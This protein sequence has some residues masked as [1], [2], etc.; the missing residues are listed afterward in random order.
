MS[1]GSAQRWLLA[2]LAVLLGAL[3]YLN[4]LH[5]PFV[6]DDHSTVVGNPSLVDLSNLPRILLHIRFRP[7]V[8]LSYALDRAVW[9]PEP[10]GFH[11]TNLMLHLLNIGLAFL[12]IDRALADRAK[13]LVVRTEATVAASAAF[14]GASLFAVH[15]LLTEAVG[16]VSARGELLATCFVLIALL[17]ARRWMMGDG[18]AWMGLA[19]TSFLLGLA[20]KE[21]AA[22][23]PFLLLAY[24]RWLGPG[25][26]ESRTRRLM[27]VHIPLVVL[28]GIAGIVRLRSYLGV[29]TVNLPRSIWQNLLTQSVIVWRYLGL[30]LWPDNQSLVHPAQSIGSLSDPRV[31]LSI[32]GVLALVVFAWIRRKQT[33]LTSLGIVWFLLG[34]APSSSLVP[35]NELMAEHRVYLPALGLSLIVAEQ[36]VR[37]RGWLEHR[38]SARRVAWSMALVTIA[39]LAGLTV[40]R[41]RAWSDPLMLWQEAAVRAPKTFAS[42]FFLAEELRRRDRCEEAIHAYQ[43]ATDLMPDEPSTPLQM[44]LCLAKLG[45]YEEAFVMFRR[46]L[47]LDPQSV[48]A[49]THL[50]YLMAGLNR[51]Q[52]A[53]MYFEGALEIRR[54]PEP[55]YYL[56]ML[57]ETTYGDSAA[58]LSLCQEAAALSVDVPPRVVD[59]VQRNQQRL[60]DEGT[61]E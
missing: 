44:G 31:V 28:I 52:E 61:S 16:Y 11:L 1:K 55:L 12:F 32:L 57:R 39:S 23:F 36:W 38:P 20:S 41:N 45:R 24:D 7:L 2:S 5:N 58:A 10:F 13:R 35:L 46:T 33:P 26:E 43:R 59:C 4:T 25:P 49:Y 3:V 47:E 51:H 40:V 17:S 9:G 53:E 18:A 60:N 8:N 22:L 21:T 48:A 54:D 29:E 42:H 56:A 15:P 50:G 14:L 30:W 34:L 6:Y 37:L 19:L 27:R